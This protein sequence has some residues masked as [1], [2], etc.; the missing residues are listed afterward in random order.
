MAVLDQ[1]FVSIASFATTAALGRMAG[2]SELALYSLAL[3]LLLLLGAAQDS[4]MSAPY[5]IYGARLKDGDRAE[6]AGCTL[7][8]SGVLALAASMMLA[9]AGAVALSRP[10]PAGLGPLLLVAAAV[11]PA[12]VLREFGRRTSAADLRIGTA[13]LLDV[14]I[15]IVQ[16]A[17]LLWLASRGALSAI[18]GLALTG[19]AN[20]SGALVWLAV[21]HRSGRIR[22]RRRRVSQAWREHWKLGRWVGAS[23]IVGHL[24][25]DPLLLWFLTFAVGASSAGAFAACLTVAFLTNPLVLGVGL[26]LTPT[27]SARFAEG[28]VRAVTRY[29]LGTTV[30]LAVVF[31]AFIAAVAV[32]GDTLLVTVYGPAYGGL[33]PAASLVALAVALGALSLGATSALL[34][35]ERPA[36]NLV[37]SVLG[38]AAMLASAS[39]LIPAYGVVGAALSFCAGNATQLLSR[40]VLLARVVAA[41]PDRRPAPMEFLRGREAL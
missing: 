16:I 39:M 35:I 33:G 23:R 17:G 11:A 21:W 29:A 12:M 27:L 20:A 2:P 40:L 5:T 22:M 24:G 3:T 34:V 1:G 9:L 13:L 30:G 28:G 38:L 19:I 15:G 36:L 10:G 32:G 31:T 14:S 4:L 18:N 7:L 41:G 6:Y 26:Y 37:A 25:S 8:F